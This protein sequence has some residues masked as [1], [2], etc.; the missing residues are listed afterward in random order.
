MLELRAWSYSC[1]WNDDPLHENLWSVL[2]QSE[3]KYCWTPMSFG[4]KLVKYILG[5][6][7]LVTSVSKFL[8]M[9]RASASPNTILWIHWHCDDLVIVWFGE[10]PALKYLRGD[11]SWRHKRTPTAFVQSSLAGLEFLPVIRK[12][13]PLLFT[14]TYITMHPPIWFPHGTTWSAKFLI[15]LGTWRL[16]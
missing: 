11:F 10:L 13:Q 5:R 3:I 4:T 6:L 12:L 9:A 14:Y 15:R 8:S 1:Q 7:Q 2:I 16:Y